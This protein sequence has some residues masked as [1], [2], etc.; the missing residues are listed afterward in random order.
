[1][2]NKINGQIRLDLSSPISAERVAEWL[3]EL[4]E[5]DVERTRVEVTLQFATGHVGNSSQARD[6]HSGLTGPERGALELVAT[7]EV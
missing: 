4:D 1:V 7:W 2:A 6:V 5:L 3:G